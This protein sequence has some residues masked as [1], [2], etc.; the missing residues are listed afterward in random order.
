MTTHR[1]AAAALGIALVALA[2]FIL[3]NPG[4]IDIIDGQWR[5]EVAYNLAR[6][7]SLSVEDPALRRSGLPGK[8]GERFSVYGIS[9][10]L[11]GLPLVAAANALIPE[12]RDLAQFMFAQTSSI[13]GATG[14]ALL[15]LIYRQLG[16]SSK[17]SLGW[18]A[19][20]GCST[21]YLPLSTSTFDQVQNAALLLWSVYAAYRA[22]QTRSILMAATGAAAFALLINYREANAIFLPALLYAS[23]V[24]H[25]RWMG[26]Q[27][28]QDPVARVFMIGAMAGGAVWVGLNY[29]RFGTLFPPSGMGYHPPAFGNPVRGLAVLTVSPAKGLLWYT[30]P[31]IFCMMGWKQFRTTHRRLAD[32]VATGTASWIALIA[33]LTFAGGD[34]CWGPRYWVVVLP[35]MFLAAPYAQLPSRTSRILAGTVIGLGLVIQMLAVSVDHQRFFFER[36]LTPFFW[37]IDESFYFRE[38]A[39]LSRVREIGR[40]ESPASSPITLPFRPGPHPESLTYTIFGPSG[41]ELKRPM[42]WIARYRVFSLPRPWPLWSAAIPD[43]RIQHWRSSLINGLFLTG[44]CGFGLM[45]WGLRAGREGRLT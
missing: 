37:Y 14:L 20:V 6:D 1:D 35:L 32:A 34:W 38:S 43:A 16:L 19:V 4:R 39:L 12:N 17:K 29:A 15:F 41:D 27:L 28:L 3:M 11:A 22:K 45:A 21:L 7:S 13:W 31:I 9:G 18:V 25:W 5:F 24:T 33:S 40:L 2:A 10:S 44:A 42:D 8:N 36:S 30:P 26:K 23:G